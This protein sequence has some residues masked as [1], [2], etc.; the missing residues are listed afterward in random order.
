M[1]FPYAYGKPHEAIPY[2][3]ESLNCK[4]RAG[5]GKRSGTITSAWKIDELNDRSR[6]EDLSSGESCDR[7]DTAT[8]AEGDRPIPSLRT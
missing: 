3:R 4:E 2:L 5:E 6:E 1:V 8:V 7:E